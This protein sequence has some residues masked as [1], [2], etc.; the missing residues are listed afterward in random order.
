M[1]FGLDTI[2]YKSCGDPICAINRR[3]VAPASR[4][5]RRAAAGRIRELEGYPVTDVFFKVY[6][7]T[8]HGTDEEAFE[9]LHHDGRRALYGVK[10]R[11][12]N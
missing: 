10:R 3:P 1:L 12:A 7:D 2:L 4:N 6:V 9:H 8:V 11:R 5:R